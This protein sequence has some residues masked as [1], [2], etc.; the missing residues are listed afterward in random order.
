MHRILLVDD[1]R[2]ALMAIKSQID[3]EQFR[4]FTAQSVA[5]AWPLLDKESFDCIL[6]DF[7][8]P[9]VSGPEFCQRIKA[10]VRLA[11][12]PVI[13]LTSLSQPENLLTAIDA[14]ADDFISKDSD[15]RIVLAKIRAMVRIKNMQEEVTKLRR[16]EGIKQIVATYNHEFNNPLTIAVGNLNWLKK[17]C[18]DANQLTRIDRLDQALGRMGELVKKIR[19]LRDYVE[20]SYTGREGMIDVAA[21]GGTKTA[22]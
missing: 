4:V 9:D 20:K 13:M 16:V 1:S 21:E 22:S 10:S 5:E 2:S 3:S 11:N 12:T 14:G 19:E 6:S 17:N 8:M 7:E 15:M 18:T